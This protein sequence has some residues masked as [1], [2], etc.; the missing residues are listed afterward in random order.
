MK[1]FKK[2]LQKVKSVWHRAIAR[3]GTKEQRSMG[4]AGVSCIGNI[5][6]AFGKIA[7]G[8]LSLNF[9]VCVNG[10]YTLGMVLAKLCVLAG[11]IKQKKYAEQYGYCYV[12][13]IILVI[14]SIA[15]ITYS[16]RLLLHPQAASYN[17]IVGITI[18]AVTFF[19][20]GLNLHGVL[21]ERNNKSPLFF[22]LK[23]INLS[24]AIICLTL[25]QTALLSFQQTEANHSVWNGVMG[26]LMG[27]FAAMLGLMIIRKIQRMKKE[28]CINGTYISCR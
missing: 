21:A 17:E 2:I 3:F 5:V 10:L 12:S 18:A 13:G 28:E 20:L 14:A 6:L 26:I 23:M 15:Y 25:T 11:F 24:S 16:I 27:S 22:V 8:L 4:V 1:L 9:Y 19:E 7:L